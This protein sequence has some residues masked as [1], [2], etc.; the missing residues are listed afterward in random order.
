MELTWAGRADSTIVRAHRHVAGACK[1]GDGPANRPTTPSSPS[2]SARVL[3]TTGHAA[4]EAGILRRG[5]AV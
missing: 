3:G 1:P 5:H 4:P 2:E